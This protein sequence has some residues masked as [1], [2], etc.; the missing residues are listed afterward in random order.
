VDRYDAPEV[1]IRDLRR[2]A[3][4]MRIDRR[5]TVAGSDIVT[6]LQKVRDA[7]NL[8]PE[9]EGAN[10][11]NATLTEQARAQGEAAIT[12]AKNYENRNRTD[13]AIKEYERAVR[14][15]EFVPGH[16]DLAL[17]RQRLAELK[18]GK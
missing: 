9:V 2:F 12:S 5:N 14:L 4:G 1:V 13:Q 17:A 7:R 11:L 8:D 3:E 16:K 18:S 15:L 10:E 6:A